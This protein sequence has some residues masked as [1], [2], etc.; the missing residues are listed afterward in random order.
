MPPQQADRR[1]RRHDRGA[2]DEQFKWDSLVSRV[3]H[4]IQVVVIEALLWV[5]L[6]IA[7][8]DVAR[9]CGGELN[10]SLVAYHTRALAARGVIE[11]VDTEVVRGAERHLYALVPGS[12]W[13]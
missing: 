1:S 8:S 9:M 5:D 3:L 12:K 13:R 10:P 2:G 6:P 7:P 11:L 4:P